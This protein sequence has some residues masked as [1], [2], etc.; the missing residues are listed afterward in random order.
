MVQL[1]SA[2]SKVGI[3]DVILKED[4]NIILHKELIHFFKL[5]K[6]LAIISQLIHILLGM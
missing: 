2:K 3:L 6:F 5:S 1:Y 4:T